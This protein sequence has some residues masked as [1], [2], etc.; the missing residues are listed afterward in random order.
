M[1]IGGEAFLWE[2]ANSLPTT[3]RLSACPLLFFTLASV[4]SSQI[5]T[6]ARHSPDK[7]PS[8]PKQIPCSGIHD[9]AQRVVDIS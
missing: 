7:L 3:W 2:E 8:Y 4:S 6:I 9:F 5:P 1:Y